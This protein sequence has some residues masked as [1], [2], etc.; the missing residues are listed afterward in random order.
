LKNE[1]K[2]PIN[3]L[4]NLAAPDMDRCATESCREEAAS[5]LSQQTTFYGDIL[6]LISD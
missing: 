3:C 5:L 4:K 1:K 6:N 2:L